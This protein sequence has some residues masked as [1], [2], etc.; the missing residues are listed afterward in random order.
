MA[1]CLTMEERLISFTLCGQEFSFY[2]DAPDEEV[3]EAV[4]LLRNELDVPESAGITTL[5]SSTMLVLAC[6]RLAARY[7]NLQNDFNRFD[8]ERTNY[9]ERK[10]VISG[11]IDHISSVL[12]EQT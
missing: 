2:S 11:M 1:G 4:T 7:V 12:E 10:R 5:P 6:L 8:S 3:E 9:E